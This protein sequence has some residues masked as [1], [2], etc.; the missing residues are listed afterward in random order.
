MKRPLLCVTA[1]FA[2]GEALTII[3][4]AGFSLAALAAVSIILCLLRIYARIPSRKACILF[5]LFWLAG[6]ITAGVQ[7]KIFD[8]EE[9]FFK[10]NDGER[11]TV[12]G[13][14]TG[15]RESGDRVRITLKCG[16]PAR[17][18]YCYAD[19]ADEIKIGMRLDLSGRAKPADPASNPGGYDFRAYCR[20]QGVGGM[21]YADDF[22]ITD[23]RYFVVREALRGLRERLSAQ[24]DRISGE[25]D[26][27][28]LKAILLGDRAELDDTLYSLYRRNGIAHLFAISGLHM[29]LVGAGLWRLLRA[30]GLGYGPSGFIAGGFLFLYGLMTGF[31]P[32]AVRAFS[33]MAVSFLASGIGRTYDMPSAL[34]VPALGLLVFRPF[35]LTQASFELSFLAVAAIRMPADLITER[36]KAGGLSKAFI[37]SASVQ[38][39]TA[40]VILWHYFELPVYA[41][42]LNII[43]IPLMPFAAASGFA[44]LFVSFVWENAG[45][46]LIGCAHYVLLF[47][48]YVCRAS[49]LMP[50]GRAAFGRPELLQIVVFYLLVAFAA[51]ATVH[52]GKKRFLIL[53]FASLFV[54]APIPVRGL[55]ITFLDVGQGDGIFMRS[56]TGN[57]LVDCGS[58]SDRK[59][60][61][62]TLVPYLKSMGITGIDAVILSHAHADHYSGI[63][64]LLENPDDIKIGKLIMPAAGYGKDE[65]EEIAELADG[66]GAPVLYMK[67][68]DTLTGGI[69]EEISVK[70]LYP[71]GEVHSDNRNDESLVLDIG[72]GAF[73]M[74]LTGDVESGGEEEILASYKDLLKNQPPVTVLKAAHH[75]SDT[76]SGKEFVET[77]N[78]PEIVISYGKNNT[79][80]HPS[81]YIMER[82][83]A[84]GA[85]IFETALDGAVTI[86]TDGKK[87]RVST[88]LTRE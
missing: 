45:V 72:Y 1:G 40:P 68:G 15:I 49:E 54:L 47:F 9:R 63:T 46:F 2:A 22:A 67:N 81:P 77:V 33:M 13:T 18:I 69:A 64:Y 14:V 65:Y 25:K 24:F 6:N 59:I 51:A 66:C 85:N 4:T 32:S 83:E 52:F 37:V 26:S 5:V 23:A 41:P 78:A 76:S 71:G 58:S 87:M 38:I 48:E 55:E 28:I 31:G 44:G 29:S 61:E 73:R 43:V 8:E 70:C 17:M 11:I 3:R 20:A 30:A 27:G 42:L 35:L 56:G 21:I 88:F 75:G 60:G 12:S 39:V 19:G 10:E 53:Y 84:T 82:F 7:V 50:F 74:L 57:M 62:N 36:L 79:Y 86:K 80:G 16:R 34:C